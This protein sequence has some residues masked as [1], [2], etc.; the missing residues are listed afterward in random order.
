MSLHV[1]S[2]HKIHSHYFKM[3]LCVINYVILRAITTKSRAPNVV[4]PDL[5]KVG[6]SA[7]LVDESANDVGGG[8]LDE[9][10]K[11]IPFLIRNT[12]PKEC[13]YL[14]GLSEQLALPHSHHLI[15]SLNGF[16]HQKNTCLSRVK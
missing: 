9:K 12:R 4:V 2:D 8:G 14:L 7:P 5:F 3:L 10:T 15:R 6:Q 13:Q 1:M 16:R 11:P